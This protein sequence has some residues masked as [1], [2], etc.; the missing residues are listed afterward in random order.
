M[1]AVSKKVAAPAPAAPAPKVAVVSAAPAPVVSAAP[2]TP[3]STATATATAAAS[4]T[5]N[6]IASA[7]L[8]NQDLSILVGALQAA[9]LGDALND[10]SLV[11]TVLAPTNAA[12]ADLLA[13]LGLTQEQ[14]LANAELLKTVLSYQ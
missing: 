10:P 1:H 3:A 7:A 14:L 9:G 8:S 11:A 2:E 12:F 5:S 13:A 4:A 6:T